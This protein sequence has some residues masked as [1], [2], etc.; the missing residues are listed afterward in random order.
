MIIRTVPRVHKVTLTF[1]SLMEEG[2]GVNTKVARPARPLGRICVSYMVEDFAVVMTGVKRV[3]NAG[4][5]S[6]LRMGAALGV[7]FAIN[8]ASRSRDSSA[9][10]AAAE[11]VVRSS[12]RPWSL[13]T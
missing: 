11:L 9:G 1:A 10:H 4:L 13:T 8:S 7:P 2:H 12:T 3:L 5:S 6:V